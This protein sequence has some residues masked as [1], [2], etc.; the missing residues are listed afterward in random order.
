MTTVE[1]PWASSIRDY[2]SLCPN[3]LLYWHILDA[4]V[5]DGCA[6]LDF[7]RSTPNEGTFK[8]KEQWGAQPVPLHWEYLLHGRRR[9]AGPE[10]EEPEVPAGDR[11]LEA[12]AAVAGQRRRAPHREVDS[13]TATARGRADD[14]LGGAVTLAQLL[15]EWRHGNWLAGDSIV[16]LNGHARRARAH[17][18]GEHHMR[19]EVTLRGGANHTGE[20][21]VAVRARPD[22][23]HAPRAPAAGSPARRPRT[24]GADDRP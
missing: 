12:A 10:P 19:I 4:A 16:Q 13:V 11:D 3:H 22:S 23:D 20:N 1:V 7:G 6:V 2:N 8:F 17:Q 21:L 5:A 15:Q 14:L 9:R 24:S 18:R